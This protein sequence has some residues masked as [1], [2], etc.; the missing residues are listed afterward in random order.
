M[1]TRAFILVLL[2]CGAGPAW[3]VTFAFV[4]TDDAP[5]SG[6]V[7]EVFAEQSGAGLPEVE[8]TAPVMSQV[9][10]VFTPQVIAVPTGTAVSFPNEDKVMHHVYSF[11]K[12][13]PF[14]LE[15]Y[16]GVA[17]SPVLFDKPGIVRLGC[18]I[19]DSMR[20]YI[21]VS[22]ADWFATSS[23]DGKVQ[24]EL[25]PGIYTLKL[26]HPRQRETLQTRLEVTQADEL[27]QYSLDVAAEKKVVRGL[28]QWAGKKSTK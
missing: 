24:A 16:K 1:F 25:A 11:S 19:H 27:L 2:T 28:K 26:W 23:A 8:A 12:A 4:N 3:A 13:K 14:E 20:G 9:G 15:L 6:V 22:E 18:N 7:V 5:L 10:Q 17:H 21:V